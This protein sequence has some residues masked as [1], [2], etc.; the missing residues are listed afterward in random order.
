MSVAFDSNVDLTVEVGFDSNPFDNSQ[1]FTDISTY[2]RGFQTQRG[3]TNELGQFVAGT[4]TLTLSN[5]DNRFNPNNTSS[6]YYD[7][8]A[9]ITKI[10]PYKA[11]KITATYNSSTYPV[12]YGYLDTV[13]VSYP[14]Q[15]SDSVVNFNAVDAF[16]ILN[17]QTINSTGWRIGRAGFSE[18]GETTSL[19]YVD[20]QEL[21]S[22]RVT[23]LLNTIQFPSSLR[24]V[25]VGTLQVQ[26]VSSIGQNVLSALRDCEVAENAQLFMSADGKATFR[27]RNYRLANTKATQVQSSFSNDGTNLPYNDVITSFDL[28]EVINVYSWTRRSGAEQFASDGD[29]VQRY[30]PIVSTQETIN[31]SDS[32]V[33]SLIQ[34]KLTET[35]M[36]IVRVDSLIANPR[37]DTSL[38]AHVLGREFGDRISVKIVNPDNSSYTE[39]LWIESISHNVNANTQT[40]LYTI[41]LSPASASAWVL[42]QAQLGVGTRFAYT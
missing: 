18:I 38:W 24:D 12:F 23:R 3:R 13:P 6:P 39:E 1:S 14:E 22:E 42:G 27:N 15:G 21:S 17:G 29:S 28:N 5:A 11:I 36:P 10:Q 33:L 7:A 31:I 41:T 34:Q 40:W 30:R 35:S 20:T 25:Q 26:T 16:K 2:V 19:S 8:T 4:L 37:Q 32:D 9:G